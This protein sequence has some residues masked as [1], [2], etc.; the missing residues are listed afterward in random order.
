MC[1]VLWCL[2]SFNQCRCININ[3]SCLH[4]DLKSLTWAKQAQ[5]RTLW[6]ACFTLIR[7][8]WQHTVLAEVLIAE[9]QCWAHWGHCEAAPLP[10]L[11][12]PAGTRYSR[13]AFR[14]WW[15]HSTRTSS[16]KRDNK[17][18][19]YFTTSSFRVHHTQLTTVKVVSLLCACECLCTSK[20]MTR[21]MGLAAL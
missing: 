4:A 20:G 15:N 19:L 1:T 14:R 18:A 12:L 21:G 6:N 10:S 9:V 16:P 7:Y 5:D 3:I 17:C 13:L 11:W 2:R 8:Y